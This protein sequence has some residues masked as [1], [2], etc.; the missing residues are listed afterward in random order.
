MEHLPYEETLPR[1]PPRSSAG[2]L[3]GVD[4]ISL[5]PQN[6]HN[7]RSPSILSQKLTGNRKR[8]RLENFFAGKARSAYELNPVLERSLTSLVPNTL[9]KIGI[10]KALIS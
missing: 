2:S 10:Y 6:V 7:T 9:Q 8:R 1:T 3:E 4:S 5:S